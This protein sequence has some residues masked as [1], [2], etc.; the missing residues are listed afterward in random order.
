MIWSAIQNRTY[1]HADADSTS[2]P[3][4]RLTR[5]LDPAMQKVLR[6]LLILNGW[7]VDDSN[8]SD[9]PVAKHNI[10]ANQQD[11]ALAVTQHVLQRVE[12]KDAGG[13]WSIL[14]PIDQQDLKRDKKYPLAYGESTQTGAYQ[15]TAGT[16]KEYD[17]RGTQ[18]F[19][20][21]KPNYT[22]T[23]SLL[24]YFARGP[25]LFDF[26]TGAF[27][28]STGSTASSP[29]F[30]SL[31]HEILCLYMAL[32]YCNLYKPERV[33]MLLSLIKQENDALDEFYGLRNK[34]HRGRLATSGDSNK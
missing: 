31:F 18:L 7:E 30:S 22:Q 19:L 25:L 17:V 34:D 24:I 3:V 9:M 11:Y 20:L 32:D 33:P 2:Y 4:A 14:T 29:G 26:T 12:L 21:P 16:P 5:A 23:N 8:Y 10:T 28:D 1:D 6:K 13:N 27:T 15:G